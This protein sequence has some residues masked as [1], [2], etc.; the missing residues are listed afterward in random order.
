[1]YGSAS[2]YALE[3][4]VAPKVPNT[5]VRLCSVEIRLAVAF[6][7]NIKFCARMYLALADPVIVWRDCA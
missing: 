2:W 4:V 6:I 7:H 1:M 5:C 3:G